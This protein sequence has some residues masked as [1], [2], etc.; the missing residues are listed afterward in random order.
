MGAEVIGA[1]ARRLLAVGL[2]ATSIAGR[3]QVPPVPHATVHEL[4]TIDGDV[5]GFVSLPSGRAVIY[6]VAN[7]NQY[8]AR[9]EDSTFVYDIATKR[10][11]LLGTNMLP[12]SVSPLGDRL[13]FTR[14]S[15]DRTEEF[16]WTMPIDPQ[17]GLA[18]GQAQRVSLR[19]T[20]RRP[21]F[22]PDGKML[23]F[24]AGPRPDGTFDTTIVPATGGVERV[25][26][27][28]PSRLG[29]G[30]SADGQFLYV[31]RDSDNPRTAVERIPVT[32]GR[33]EPLVPRTLFTN[34]N[35]VGLS[36]DGRVAFFLAN[37]DRFFYRTA[38]GVEGEIAVSLPA[39]DEGW[40]YNLTLDAKLRYVTMTQVRNY[41]VRILDLT[42][43]QSR[44]LLGERVQSS[45]PAWSP[46]G[47]RLA[48]LTGNL[49][50]YD[51]TVVNADGSSPR[52]YP[53][54]LHLDGWFGRSPDRKIWDTPW[55]PDGR[56]L[57]FRANE[58]PGKDPQKVGWSP[59]DKH[60]LG[61][62]DVNSGET[63][64]LTTSS[65]SMGRFVWR[66][67][68]TGIRTLKRTSVP[69]GF[70]TQ[71]SVVE[72]PLNGVER[73][74]LDVSARFPEV[75]G[76]AFLSDRA[77]VVTVTVD[78]TPERFLVPLDG[79][80]TRRLPT[81]DAEAGLRP[82]GPGLRAGN[83]ILVPQVDERGEAQVIN[84][85]STVGDATRTLR[86][87]FSNPFSVVFPDGLRLASIGRGA[88]DSAWNVFVVPLNGGVPT[89]V[90][91][92]AFDPSSS[93][94]FLAPSP[95]GKQL[96]YM[97]QG[98]YTSTIFE[99]DFAPALQALFNR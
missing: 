27:N 87:P 16:V 12:A 2:L 70:R 91:E 29:V 96:A 71:L 6:T 23:A 84:I 63:R 30:W 64:L 88:D 4:V 7:S 25:V 90:G 99:I 32:G 14:A 82:G 56:Y 89:Q 60:Q 28:H 34:V 40:G 17:T 97:T 3:A 8:V 75:T 45:T 93:G 53:M 94:G 92:I 81:P 67:D 65:S 13:A 10:H 98:R 72:I 15:E 86:L 33:S 69:N 79:G 41:R 26:A 35:A 50:H 95:D 52:T 48:V 37:P 59:E 83:R 42:T 51:V 66:A 47:R 80:E 11:T 22:S 49:S 5:S 36:P 18:T 24:Y 31:E 85:L 46:D 68:G 77:V 78:G 19:P 43:G 21:V 55:S 58:A 62:L 1:R 38:S 39:R 57:A 20:R 61:L 74:L 73:S 76:V 54:P 44:D 9:I